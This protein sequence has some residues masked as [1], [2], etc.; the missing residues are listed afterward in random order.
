MDDRHFAR[1]IQDARIRKAAAF[2]LVETYCQ[3]LEPSATQEKRAKESYEA[4]G[5]WLATS[6]HPVLTCTLIYP[7]G[8]A[9]TGTMV[10]PLQ[11]NEH[12]VDLISLLK[13]ATKFTPPADVKKAIGDRL[14]SNGLYRDK[15]QEMAR[16]WRIN[17]ANEFHLDITPSIKNPDCANGGELVP[18][19][20]LSQW[21]PSNPLGFRD[22][23]NRRA[24]L[25]PVSR[26]RKAD[27]VAASAEIVPF[28]KTS[29]IKGVLRRTVQLL[30]RHRDVYFKNRDLSLAPLS[31]IISTLA[32]RSYEWCV[33]QDRDEDDDFGLLLDTI[34]LMPH[35]IYAPVI[36]DRQHWFVMNE[37]TDGENFAEKWNLEPARAQSF[38][39]WHARALAD[40]TRL[41]EF[42]GL[43]AMGTELSDFL[44][45]QTVEKAVAAVTS[46]VSA[47]RT[48]GRLVAGVGGLAAV[49][50]PA[51]VT[52]PVRAN[53][54]FGK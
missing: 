12:D 43:D 37:T 31:I 50:A 38:Y 19:K 16:C 53:T 7:Q 11:G 20:N 32:S 49:T 46:Q 28:P 48:S 47:A 30:K 3:Q 40:F 10:K 45:R 26:L 41:L 54:F 4:V 9:S 23:F 13:G 42:E 27:S 5:D 29:P 35:Y 39:A 33:Q 52:T 51:L 1:Q 25:R 24:A 36:Q 18:D 14:A 6:D 21:K 17:Y 22:L 34:R 15:L 2:S 44:D 8:S